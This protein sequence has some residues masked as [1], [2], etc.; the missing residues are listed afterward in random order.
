VGNNVPYKFI[1]SYLLSFVFPRSFP[2]ILRAL[3]ECNKRDIQVVRIFTDSNY[4][5]QGINSWIINWR[6]NGWKTAKGAPVKNK[7]LWEAIDE[8]RKQL[9]IVEWRWV[10]AHNGHPQNEAVDRLARECA[11]NIDLQ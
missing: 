8:A 6:K 11:K 10:K 2:A 4:V 7:E 5:K 1:T 9:Q 3:E